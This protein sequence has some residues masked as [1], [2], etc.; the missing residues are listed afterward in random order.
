MNEAKQKIQAQIE[1]Y[2]AEAKRLRDL[3]DDGKATDADRHD[4]I[5]TQG[6][7]IGLQSALIV[8]LECEGNQ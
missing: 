6:I 8:V 2:K 5:A 1:T 4:I 3:R 7:M